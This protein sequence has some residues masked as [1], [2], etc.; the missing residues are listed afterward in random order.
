MTQLTTLQY[1][2]NAIKSSNL[3]TLM[4]FEL[5]IIVDRAT[6]QKPLNIEYDYDCGVRV[7]NCPKCNKLLK[8]EN[9]KYCPY[10]GKAFINK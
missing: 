6:P 1:M 7:G 3:H 9:I 2:N 5:Y 10:C 8:L 4:K